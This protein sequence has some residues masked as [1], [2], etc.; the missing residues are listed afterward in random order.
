[1]VTFTTRGDATLDLI[2]TNFS[3]HSKDPV[4]MPALINTDHVCIL[5]RP[6]VQVV[7]HRS[8][9]RTYRPMK[10][11]QLREFDVWIQNEDWSNVIS[12]E[13][14]QQKADAL[15]ESL[16]GAI[17]RFFPMQTVKVHHN[18]KPWMSQTVK[19]LWKR[20]RL[21]LN[22]VKTRCTIRYVIMSREREREGQS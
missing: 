19:A 15:Y 16:R 3:V 13:N 12:A 17:D 4:P 2:M 18:S 1:M 14:T 11:S 7:K 5:W 10:D 22:Q 20:D 21:P 6:E 9:K 8:T